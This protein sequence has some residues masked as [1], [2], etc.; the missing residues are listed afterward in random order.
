MSVVSEM[1]TSAYLTEL[2]EKYK[3]KYGDLFTVYLGNLFICLLKLNLQTF[4]SS[5]DFDSIIFSG[6]A[7]NSPDF[8][9]RKCANYCSK[10]FRTSERSLG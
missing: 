7:S 5:H 2:M 8:R 6:F 1:S 10:Q 3:K 4:P 9:F